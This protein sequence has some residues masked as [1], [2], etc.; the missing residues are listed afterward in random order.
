M[1]KLLDIKNLTIAYSKIDNQG[2][3]PFVKFL[4][5]KKKSFTLLRDV[6]L[7]VFESEYLGLVGESG[8]GK[9]LTMKSIFGMID[10]DPGIVNG[11]IKINESLTSGLIREVEEETSLQVKEPSFLEK[12]EGFCFGKR[13]D[14]TSFLKLFRFLEI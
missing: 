11:H 12:E 10:F 5:D 14:S 7:S 3:N 6:T 13:E 1:N 9:S 2:Q 4:V 8:C